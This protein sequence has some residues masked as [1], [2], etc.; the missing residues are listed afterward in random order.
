MAQ[1]C[2]KQEIESILLGFAKEG[3]KVKTGNFCHYCV[4]IKILIFSILFFIWSKD[5]LGKEILG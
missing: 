4:V 5:L 1:L 2:G 3:E